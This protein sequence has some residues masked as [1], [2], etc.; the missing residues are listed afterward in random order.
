MLATLPSP[1]D[2]APITPPET[3]GYKAS[4]TRIRPSALVI[5]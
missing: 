3:S 2:I 1:E 4:I 5:K